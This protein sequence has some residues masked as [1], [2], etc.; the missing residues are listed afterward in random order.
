MIG[1]CSEKNSARFEDD[2][3]VYAAFAHRNGAPPDVVQRA[4]RMQR[5]SVY[6]RPPERGVALLEEAGFAD[7]RL[8]YVGLWVCDGLHGHTSSSM[9]RRRDLLMK[10]QTFLLY[11]LLIS[12]IYQ[13][14]DGPMLCPILCPM[15]PK[16][17]PYRISRGVTR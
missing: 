9:S 6:Y 15:C 4:V 13:D 3:R 8:C 12:D 1:G 5:E 11:A 14:I 16:L 2:L 7:I 17:C 10:T